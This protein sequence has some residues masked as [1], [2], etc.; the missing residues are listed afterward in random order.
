MSKIVKELILDNDEVTLPGVG[1][2]VA[3][4]VPSVFSDKGYTINPPYK[5]LSFRQKEADDG[6]LLINFYAKCNNLDME[7]ASKIMHEFLKEMRHILEVKKTILF[8][9]LGKLRATRENCFFFVADED[10]DIYP[11]GFGLEPI[12]LKTHEE[13]PAE[14]SVTMAALRSILGGEDETEEKVGRVN[15]DGTDA[16]AGS[17]AF[18]AATVENRAAT[19]TT[20]E[21]GIMDAA[22]H[23]LAKAS[24]DAGAADRPMTATE[25]ETGERTLKETPEAGATTDIATQTATE[26]AEDTAADDKK[27]VSEKTVKAGESATAEAPSSHKKAAEA[28][29]QTADG[30]KAEATA[31]AVMAGEP[32]DA[33]AG[34]EASVTATAESPAAETADISDESGTGIKDTGISAAKQDTTETEPGTAT[35]TTGVSGITDAAAHDL[36]KTSADAG[37]ANRPVAAAETEA[38]AK[39]RKENPIEQAEGTAEESKAFTGTVALSIAAK[40]DSEKTEEQTADG[41]KAEAA[42]DGKK[43]V[44]AKAVT[45]G[46]SVMAETN[47]E[48]EK[49]TVGV[50]SQKEASV[51]AG[52]S[53]RPE[54]AAETEAAARNVEEPIADSKAAQATE[55]PKKTGWK[56]LKWT[57]ITLLILAVTALAAFMILAHT[58]PDFIDSILYTPEE[59]EILNM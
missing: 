38:A 30:I 8:P 25:T 26:R 19:G 29:E 58:A 31:T 53:D 57:V 44:S 37:L 20:G 52:H 23:D 47:C 43:E 35:D 11:E 17:K 7:T 9:G 5:R 59:L 42:A 2:F 12:S 49:D 16:A 39:T 1:S 14:V 10:L 36:A 41:M 4:L 51:G 48:A 56:I 55:K 6:K 15:A 50:H 34:S 21:S 3:E 28:E 22:V 45:A 33:E 54:A 40:A 24:G 13:T 46:E 27:E 32:A 18:V